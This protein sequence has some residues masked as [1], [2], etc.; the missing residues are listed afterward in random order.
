MS[1]R[2]GKAKAR[3]LSWG[4]D[5]L[6][7]REAVMIGLADDRADPVLPAALAL[8]GRLAELPLDQAAAV[9]RYFLEAHDMEGG[10]RKANALFMRACASDKAQAS[11]SSFG[12]DHRITD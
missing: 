1:Q 5:Q 3:R 8:A 4:V 12:R 6:D 9:K 11:F 10:D 2:V 7:G